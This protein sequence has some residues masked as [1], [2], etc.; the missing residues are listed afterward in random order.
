[1]QE[2][3]KSKRNFYEREA[4][5]L[6]C[7]QRVRHQQKKMRPYLSSAQNSFL[8]VHHPDIPECELHHRGLGWLLGILLF[9]LCTKK[10]GGRRNQSSGPCAIT[11]EHGILPFI[12]LPRAWPFGHTFTERKAGGSCLYNTQPFAL[13]KFG[14]S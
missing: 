9:H 10:S 4:Y 13:F 1:M 8:L 3:I 7:I 11:N 2:V 14:R 5:S 12:S 6:T